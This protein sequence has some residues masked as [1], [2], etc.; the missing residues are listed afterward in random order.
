MTALPP[1]STLGILG[2]GQLGRM[3]AMAAASLGYR[4]HIFTPDINSPASFVAAATTVADY[5]NQA[6]LAAFASQVDAITIEF[7]NIPTASLDFLA[8][9]RPTAPGA[10]ALRIT[11]D[12]LLE[13]DFAR[14]HGAGTA[15]YRAIS[16]EADCA[17]ARDF[18]FPAILKTRRF[19]YDGKGQIRLDRHEDLSQ[20]WTSLGRAPCILEARLAFRRE[21]SVIV[22]RG[23]DGS[24][25]AYDPVE[26]RHKNGILDVTLAGAPFSHDQMQAARDLACDLA[27]GLGIVGMLA[28][29]LFE[30][31]DG[32]LLVNEMAPRVH[33]SGH[34]TIEG[35]DCSQFEQAVRA[36]LGLPL[37]AT[38]RRANAAMKNLIGE[39]AQDWQRYLSDPKVHLHLYGKA[40]ARA[41]RKMGHVTWLFPLDVEP[42]CPA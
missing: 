8:Q 41:G 15:D 28:V 39:E 5:E 34:W 1:G 35:A 17:A 22:A 23:Y 31:Q 11:Q 30:L 38:A 14:K 4:V 33:N 24:I 7:E 26:N 29:E 16:S 42:Y 19:G 9:L 3:M 37:G 18:S 40:E 27:V 36:A 32:S 21:L 10:A 20:A 6:A 12:R 2:G 13:K 25:A